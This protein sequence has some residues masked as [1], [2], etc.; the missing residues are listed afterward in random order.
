MSSQIR[1]IW[2]K[3]GHT[4]VAAGSGTACTP[5]SDAPG[6][7]GSNSRLGLDK[8][9]TGLAPQVSSLGGSEEG[10]RGDK[11]ELH[12]GMAWSEGIRVKKRVVSTGK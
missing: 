8:L 6:V 10:E 7:V 1:E 3:K 11:R 5:S 9:H 4:I 12:L 2:G